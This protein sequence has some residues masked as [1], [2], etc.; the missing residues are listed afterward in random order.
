ML[1]MRSCDA[2]VLGYS[3][4]QALGRDFGHVFY[5]P[6]SSDCEE[7]FGEALRKIFGARQGGSHWADHVRWSQV[8][9]LEKLEKRILEGAQESIIGDPDYQT[10][11]DMHFSSLNGRFESTWEYGK[12]TLYRFSDGRRDD[13]LRKFEEFWND[14]EKNRWKEIHGFMREHTQKQYQEKDERR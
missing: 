5:I 14:A 4:K 13:A 1:W 7:A 2:L 9:H 11:F 12:G 3:P 8:E 10:G 6:C